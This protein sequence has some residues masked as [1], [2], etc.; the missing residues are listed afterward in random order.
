M[1]GYAAGQASRDEMIKKLVADNA[2]LT[3][4]HLELVADMQLL[5]TTVKEC[6]PA[7]LLGE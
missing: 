2:D 7:P 1:K 3:Q 4:K 6:R 5:V